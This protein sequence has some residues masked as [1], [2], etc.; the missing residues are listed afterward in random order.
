MVI[1]TDNDTSFANQR[2][3][4]FCG[5]HQ[6]NLKYASVWHP[7]TNGQ[8]E[9]ANKN[10]L[11]ILK[12]RLDD[13]KARWP[14]ELPGALWAYNTA[15]SEV[16]QESPFSLSFGMDAII[17]VE[18]EHLSPKIEAA[19]NFKPEALQTWMNE[20]DDSRRIDLDLLEQKRKLAALNRLEHKHR[21]E[22]YFNR[23]V[24]PRTFIQGDLVL[25]RRLLAGSNLGVPKLE[26]NWE[27][28]YIVCEVAGP[29]AY[30]LTTSEGIQLPELGVE[31]T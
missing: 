16:T 8:A 11:N 14:E 25:K 5:E 7:H 20:N 18:L 19:A 26:P 24:N 15:P 12:K 1:I 4:D 21:M 17:P 9:A 30:Y 10:I 29:N 27:G 6:I 13:A 23:R 28:P 22:R 3:H 2:I 31:M